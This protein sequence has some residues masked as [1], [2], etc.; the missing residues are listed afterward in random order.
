MCYILKIKL[1]NFNNKSEGSIER[2]CNSFEDM[3]YNIESIRKCA[4]QDGYK[5]VK[6]EVNYE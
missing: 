4:L 3:I 5:I 2:E 6:I 1:M